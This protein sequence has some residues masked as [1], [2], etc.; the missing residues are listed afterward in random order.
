MRRTQGRRPR[1]AALASLLMSVALL[2][3]ACSSSIDADQPADAGQPSDAAQPARL[4]SPDDF[5]AAVAEPDRVTVN[6]H[7]PFEGNIAGTDLSVRYDDVRAARDRLPR[8]DIPLAIYC[9]SGSMSE[10]AA[11]ELSDM[12]YRDIVELEGG[13]QAWS[14][15]GRRLLGRQVAG[16]AT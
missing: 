7:V 1:A 2:L 3:S 6:V 11:L 4:L 9:R 8:T 12:G 14:D 5:A 16:P 13:M 10:E 15:A